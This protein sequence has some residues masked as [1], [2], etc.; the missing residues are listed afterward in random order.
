MHRSRR[1]LL[2]SALLVP[3]ILTVTASQAHAAG[4][5]DSAANAFKGLESKWFNALVG[6]AKDLFTALA[7][8]E[9]AWLGV[10]WLLNRRTFDEI[11]PSL[12]K[13]II[14]I[15]FFFAILIN[16][17]SWVPDVINGF[18][19][20]GQQAG[21]VGALSPST[22]M[23][24]GISDT[25]QILAGNTSTGG[26]G[27]WGSAVSAIKSAIDP[28]MWLEFVER[29]LIAIV[30]F[31]S[32]AYIAIE[33]L[34]LLVESYL[35]LGAGVIFL[36]FGGSRWTTR[37][38]DGYLNFAVS[39]GTKLF[40]I[41]LIVGA[42]V[43]SVIPQINTM[44]TSVGNFNLANGLTAA[45]VMAAAAMLAKK[46]PDHAGALLGSGAGLTAAA[47]GAES[48]KIAMTAG[49]L[50]AG[51]VT[52]GAAAAPAIAA[53]SMAATTAIGGGAAGMSGASMASLGLSAA[54]STASGGGVAASSGAAGVAAPSIFSGASGTSGSLSG[55][56]AGQNAAMVS[57]PSSSVGGASSSVP[58]P[59]SPA[60]AA[61]STGQSAPGSAGS[62]FENTGNANGS[63]ASAG[64]SSGSG[65][66][67]QSGTGS[68]SS[69]G[70]RTSGSQYPSG[71]AT[72]PG[73]AQPNQF[74]RT[75][76]KQP[77]AP[78]PKTLSD[79]ARQAAEAL[80]KSANAISHVSAGSDARVQASHIS[81]SHGH[82]V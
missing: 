75:Q 20:A 58:A 68:N 65:D 23:S 64:G 10:N 44:L 76:Q 51:A 53:A 5:L 12:A 13:K 71:S 52:A 55:A 49:T 63:G 31:L 35:I 25:L 17:Q 67:P 54:G 36:G 45:A 21:G 6:D 7:G 24:Y 39:V 42:L 22:I 50:A 27:F 33:M 38:V 66:M 41:Y 46:V 61:G 15:G 37:F 56:T 40:V 29:I 26:G 3:L 14:T 62:L 18:T 34:V 72:N 70:P 57:G 28:A 1:H 4:M 82:D 2:L 19:M 47:L 79:R 80:K 32:F 78:A 11:I 60:S 43:T 73:G 16:A 69:Q 59:F 9:M 81:T 74:G 48:A 8:L 77:G 30:I